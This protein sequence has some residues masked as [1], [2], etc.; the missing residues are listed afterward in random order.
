[1]VANIGDPF[2]LKGPNGQFKFN[3]STDK[4]A[5]FLAGGTGLAPF[6][7]M[8]RHIK[9]TNAGTDAILMYSVK[10]PTEV[11]LKDEL[12]RLSSELKTKLV[13]TVTRPQ[14]DPQA[15]PPLQQLPDQFNETGHIDA[16]MI[17]KYCKDLGE[18]TFYICGPLKFVQALK[19]SLASLNIP[20]DK[21][22]AD[23]WG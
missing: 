3:P 12:V 5:V 21:V 18:R 15:P 10:Y 16:N 20:N 13:V 9:L 8:L 17:S 1:M 11:I 23:V 14:S 22:K 4:K 7:S 2:I 6:M 19:Q